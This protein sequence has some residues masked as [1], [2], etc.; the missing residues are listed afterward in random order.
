MEPRS[1][2]RI[3][4][5][6]I[7]SC[8]V[9]HTIR[10]VPIL[11]D[12]I[13]TSERHE[14]S[15]SLQDF[16]RQSRVVKDED[17]EIALSAYTLAHQR[18]LSA[19]RA[20][21]LS[22]RSDATN[23][24]SIPL[25]TFFPALKLKLTRDASEAR[26][27]PQKNHKKLS[28]S[29]VSTVKVAS[30]QQ[31]L[32]LRSVS[33]STSLGHTR[34]IYSLPGEATRSEST[35]K[36]L[37]SSERDSSYPP[38][39]SVEL[40]SC[41]PK[42]GQ[43]RVLSHRK[44][45]ETILSDAAVSPGYS[46]FPRTQRTRQ[47][48]VSTT[49]EGLPKS[50]LAERQLQV[51]Q[52]KSQEI[53]CPSQPLFQKQENAI[54]ALLMMPLNATAQLKQ[55]TTE[56]AEASNKTCSKISDCNSILSRVLLSEAPD[57]CTVNNGHSG[58]SQ[59]TFDDTSPDNT[60]PDNTSQP[61][62]DSVACPTGLN[63]L[64]SHDRSQISLQMHVRESLPTCTG[65]VLATG[66]TSETLP[67]GEPLPV[68]VSRI[69]I[70]PENIEEHKKTGFDSFDDLLSRSTAW[71]KTNDSSI[72]DK[73]VKE[74]KMKIAYESKRDLTV[75]Q[76]NCHSSVEDS[77]TVSEPNSPDLTTTAEQTDRIYDLHEATI[78]VEKVTH[79]EAFR[80]AR[81]K[82]TRLSQIGFPGV[83]RNSMPFVNV[84]PASNHAN[85]IT[86]SISRSDLLRKQLV[87]ITTSETEPEDYQ[88]D[89]PTGPRYSPLSI[90]SMPPIHYGSKNSDASAGIAGSLL[91]LPLTSSSAAAKIRFSQHKRQDTNSSSAS[92]DSAA[93]TLRN[94]SKML[95]NLMEFEKLF[96]K[97]PLRKAILAL[98]ARVSLI[99]RDTNCVQYSTPGEVCKQ[100]AKSGDTSDPACVARLPQDARAR[101]QSLSAIIP[102][103]GI[104]ITYPCPTVDIC[105]APEFKYPSL[106]LPAFPRRMSML[107]PRTISASQTPVA[108]SVVDSCKTK[109]GVESAVSP[110]AITPAHVVSKGSLTSHGIEDDEFHS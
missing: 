26:K 17:D 94:A 83:R 95:S 29:T 79:A 106:A 61:V 13:C 47:A 51:A 58:C 99:K 56:Q 27:S 36:V 22:R 81:A 14:V 35:L 44:Q 78:S 100:V 16:L 80:R 87:P 21:E 69:E 59:I 49:R 38:S 74:Q 34:A 18:P 64:G 57:E 53:S 20:P 40:D 71:I 103:G 50:S 48:S 41:I 11:R 45:T 89:S 3:R 54:H 82:I 30:S 9:L 88:P 1:A 63:S 98:G 39:R 62:L 42:P 75:V 77:A 67:S 104:P 96:P 52:P 6:D 15:M 85:T 68:V 110:C 46:I 23:R 76:L 55:G 31:G 33:P 24:K 4:S 92:G 2:G 91:A 10:S 107:S 37:R 28:I 5:K 12:E 60:S 86:A 108:V 101:A 109:Q 93:V 43:S 19:S 8:H 70:S 32:P 73:L 97:P 66:K 65:R 7:R 90:I 105:P 25:S 84:L 72:I 102:A